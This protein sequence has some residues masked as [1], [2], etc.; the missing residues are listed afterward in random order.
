MEAILGVIISVI[1]LLITPVKAIWKYINKKKGQDIKSLKK[2]TGGFVKPNDG[3]FVGRRV[4]C[5]GWIKG[6]T[7]NQHFWLVKE[8]DDKFWPEEGQ[9]KI[10]DGKWKKIVNEGGNPPNGNIKIAI[11]GT[12]KYGN[13]L[14][15][16]WIEE[17][18]RT[19]N[20][21][22]LYDMDG[23][24]KIKSIELKLDPQIHCKKQSAF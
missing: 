11:C 24:R 13:N 17:T 15:L 22:G 8:V 7:K 1:N 2:V 21:Y 4:K 20:Y 6:N 14:I 3:D 12:N 16:N 9:I 5:E 23:I 10:E 19:G 18:K